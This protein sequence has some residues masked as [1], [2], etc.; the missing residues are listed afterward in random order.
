MGILLESS[1]SVMEL[2][3]NEGNIALAYSNQGTPHMAHNSNV[4]SRNLHWMK[5]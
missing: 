1:F 4:G 2:H 5:T 3:R